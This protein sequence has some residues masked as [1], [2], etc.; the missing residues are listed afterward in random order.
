MHARQQAMYYT[1]TD[2]RYVRAFTI[3]ARFADGTASEIDLGD[4]LWGSIFEPSKDVNY[5]PQL[6][7][8]RVR[9]NLLAERR[10]H[11]AGVFVRKGSR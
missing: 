3:W 7:T 6:I 1:V 8:R 11:R 2:A 5:F 4:E 9:H 10:G